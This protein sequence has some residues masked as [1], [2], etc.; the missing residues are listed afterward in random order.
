MLKRK[1]FIV[2]I[3]A[4]IGAS[5]WA[6]DTATFVDLGF[7]P[8]GKTY[9]FGQYGIQSETLKPW[10]DL[11]VVDVPLNDFVSGGRIT[12]THPSPVVAG[13]D[14]SGA[15]YRLTAKNA[16]LAERYKIDYLFQG[17][18]LYITLEDNDGE[19]NKTA[20]NF[21]DFES[22]IDYK[23]SLIPQ[24]EGSGKDLKSSFYINLESVAKNGAKMT[25]TV[26]TP[27]L[28]RA[29]IASYTIAKV[30][31]APRDGSMIFVIRMKRETDTGYDIRY[32]VEA[33][34]L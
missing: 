9:M 8:D 16:A 10:A 18:P 21:R 15:L 12:Y 11:Y 30:M 33:V 31:I 27:Q 22:N 25:Y 34:R 1:I 19:E 13:Q 2:V 29:L 3:F 7:S 5:L 6:G 4:L 24:I 23:A 14:G 20:I 17:K 28:K 32:M 26:G